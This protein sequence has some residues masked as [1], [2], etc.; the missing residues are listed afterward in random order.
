MNNFAQVVQEWQ[1]FYATIAAA[2]ATLVGLLFVGLAI[3]PN[4]LTQS[5]TRG[6]QLMARETFSSFVYVIAVALT[7]LIPRLD[8]TGLGIPMVIIGLVGIY[9][10]AAALVKL[11][12][13]S[14]SQEERR[15][16]IRRSVPNLVSLVLLV[17]IGGLLWFTGE[18]RLLWWMI[19]PMLIL[20]LNA[21][22]NTW[23]LFVAI[24][25]ASGKE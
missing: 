5:N 16:G 21:S 1:T 8:P 9:Y 23:T 7:F 19:A 25:Q 4:T 15:V 14:S 17:V 3:S 22:L 10:T 11:V 6:I 13:N 24:Q 12:R 18:E 20:L 2:S